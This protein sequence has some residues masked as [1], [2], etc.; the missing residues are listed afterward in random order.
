M[1]FEIPSDHSPIA[2]V[3]HSSWQNLE[4]REGKLK[5]NIKNYL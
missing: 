4:M 1:L 2:V 3:N 5:H